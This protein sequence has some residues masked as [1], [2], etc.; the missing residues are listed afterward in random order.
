MPKKYDCIELIYLS[1]CSTI[2]KIWNDSCNGSC[3]SSPT[4]IYHDQELHKILICWGACWLHKKRMAAPY[5][6]LQLHID[7]PISKAF[8]VN[9]TKFHAH[10]GGNFLSTCRKAQRIW[11][12]SIWT[13]KKNIYIIKKVSNKAASGY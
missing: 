2:S 1:I 11:G 9:L 6:L 3:G 13:R 4:C 10:V 7:L 5:T 8:D 12:M